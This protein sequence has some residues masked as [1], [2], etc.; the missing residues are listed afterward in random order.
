MMNVSK[1]EQLNN[2]YTIISAVCVFLFICVFFAYIH[3]LAVFDQDD[4]HYLANYRRPFPIWEAW[5]PGRVMPEILMPLAG[6][7]AAYFVAPLNGD[8]VTAV[9]LTCAVIMGVVIL[10]Y[11]LVFNKLVETTFGFKPAITVMLGLFFV[12]AHFSLLRSQ[13]AGNNYLFY[14][15][16]LTCYFF[17]II[18]FLLNAG[19]VMFFLAVKDFPAYYGTLD[20]SKKGCF[21]VLLYLAIFSNLFGSVIL[22]AFCMIQ[23]CERLYRKQKG[24]KFHLTILVLWVV[25]M[26]FEVN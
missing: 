18:P 11:Y 23:L 25:S 16:D 19:L 15:L 26:I 5:N 20:N 21:V 6:Y 10:A 8:Y 14:G 9:T 2:R 12:L 7:I 1:L 24:Y 22:A 3:P 17:Y 4:W 13:G